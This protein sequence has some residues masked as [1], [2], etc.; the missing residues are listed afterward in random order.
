MKIAFI[1]DLHANLVALEAVLA[2]IGSVGVDEIICLGDI[3]SLGPQP[4][5]VTDRIRGLGCAAIQGNHDP[6][7]EEFSVLRELGMWTEQQL[8]QSDKLFL[9]TLP[10]TLDRQIEDLKLLCVHGSPRSFDEQILDSTATKDLDEMFANTA[11]DLLAS[12]HTHVQLFRRLNGRPIV[13]VG[14]VGMPYVAP[15][16]GSGAPRVL[17]VSEYAIVG[18]EAGKLAVDLRQVTYDFEAYRE[19]VKTSGMPFPDWCEQWVD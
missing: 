13:G 17:K 10:S 9:R 4:C 5:E 8:S 6:L 14:S 19:S 3:A 18:Y 16:D 1:S 7:T 12:G 11:F 15:F 2:D